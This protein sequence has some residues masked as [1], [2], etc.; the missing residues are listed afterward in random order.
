MAD[1]TR[2]FMEAFNEAVAAAIAEHHR[3]GRSV[4][5]MDADG[6]L[7]E[8][9]PEGPPRK[10]SEVE[11]EIVLRVVDWAGSLEQAW[12]WYRTQALSG[13]GFL[14]PDELVKQGRAEAVRSYLDRVGSGGFA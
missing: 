5:G 3:A 8:F 9:P 13:F 7:C 10:L 14:T 6:D 2:Q 1:F 4:Y 11:V 12:A